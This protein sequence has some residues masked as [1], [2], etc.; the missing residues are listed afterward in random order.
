MIA[1][2][3]CARC[4]LEHE[5]FPVAVVVGDAVIGLCER[6]VRSALARMKR[7]DDPCGLVWLVGYGEDA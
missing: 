4:R 7:E 1:P 2:T 5:R 6:C 3:R